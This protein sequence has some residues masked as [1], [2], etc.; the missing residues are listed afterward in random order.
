VP[1]P[2]V[3]VIVPEAELKNVCDCPENNVGSPIV[4]P[5]VVPV[6]FVNCPAIGVVNAV[7]LAAANETVGIIEL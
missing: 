6:N 5:N 2:A 3:N 1:E 4:T 7:V